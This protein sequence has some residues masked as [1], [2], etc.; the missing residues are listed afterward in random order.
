MTLGLKFAWGV[1][2]FT[3]AFLNLASGQVLYINEFMAS[4]TKTLTDEYAEYDDW[5]EIYNPGDTGVDLGGMYLTDDLTNLTKCRIPTTDPG[6]TTI[7]PH[8]FM[9]F[10]FDDKPAQGVRHINTKL[11]GSG[12]Q[13]GLVAA[14]G[15]TIIDSITFGQQTADVS[16][17]RKPD[18]TSNWFLF[19]QATPGAANTTGGVNPPT[20]PP[21]FSQAGGFYTAG[22]DLTLSAT[23]PTAHICYT[24]D[25]SEPT[26]NASL[27]PYPY[28]FQEIRNL[29]KVDGTGPT[30]TRYSQTYLYSG[31][32]T[33]NPTQVNNPARVVRARVFDSGHSPSPIITQTYIF[34]NTSTLPVLSL[35]TTPTFLWSNTNN[36]DTGGIFVMGPGPYGARE[37]WFDPSNVWKDWERP[38]HVE[39]F[40]PSGILAFSLDAGIKLT[41][42]TTRLT[43]Q[44]PVTIH[45]RGDYGPKTIPYQVFPD[46]P[47]QEFGAL[48]FRCSGDDW[49]YT[50]FQ[51][52]MIT[53]L[54]KDLDVDIQAYR[55]AKAYVNGEY[56]GIYEIRER[57]NEEYLAAHYG[58]DSEM[59]DILEN[60]Q[61]VAAGDATN[62]QALMTYVRSH[63]TSLATTYSD[64]KGLMEMDNYIDYMITEIYAANTDWPGGNTRYWR[65]KITNGR[66]R[67]MLH[68]LD[69]GFAAPFGNSVSALNPNH[70]TLAFA[71]SDEKTWWSNPTWSTELFRKLLQSSEF[72]KE[73][74]RRFADY[75]NITFAPA[76]VIQH[77]NAKKAGI[78]AEMGAQIARWKDD[79]TPWSDAEGIKMSPIADL[80]HWNIQVNRLISFANQRPNF[81]R[82]HLQ[83][84][85]GYD[86][87][88]VTFNITPAGAGKIRVNRMNLPIPSGESWTGIYF[89]DVQLQMLALPNK[90]F[91]FQNWVGLTGGAIASKTPTGNLNITANFTPDATN[92][93]AV[94]ITEINYNSAP[95]FTP[96]N[97][98]ELYN[99]HDFPVDLSGW[100]FKD[101]N[102]NHVFVFP[103]NTAIGPKW[104][105]VLCEDK[106]SFHNCF[107]QVD[108]YIGN[109]GFGLKDSGEQLRLYDPEGMLV[110]SLIYDDTAPWPTE[111][112]GTGPT[113]ELKQLSLDNSLPSSW[114]TSPGHGSP[115]K[116]NS[117]H[118]YLLTTS[119]VNEHGTLSPASKYCDKN[120]AETLTATPDP[121]YRVKRWTGTDNDTSTATTNTITM[122]TAKTVTVEFELITGTQYQLTTTV[123]GGH[124]TL[125]PATGAFYDAGTVVNLAA[126]PNSGYRVKKWT[127]TDN[128]SSTSGSNTVTM[129]SAKT[130]TVEFELI[131][132]VRY[133]LTGS[134]VS[135]HGTIYPLSAIY[136]PGKTV[137]LTAVPDPGYRVKKWTGT[138]NDASTENTNTVTMTSDKTVTVEF[139]LIPIIQYKLTATVSGGNGTLFPPDGVFDPGKTVTLTATANSGYR[140]KKWTGTNYDTSTAKTNTVTMNSD[141]TVTVEFEKIDGATILPSTSPTGTEDGTG[142]TE[143]TTKPALPCAGAGPLL[144]V[145]LCLA[146]L[147]LG[148]AKPD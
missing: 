147:L 57:Q 44:K 81:V 74:V 95:D 136:D 141:K 73:F 106:I 90:G 34:N 35:S 129:A 68:D 52:A 130:V 71:S 110:D 16:Q 122:N 6:G 72:E 10:W 92:D 128:D 2:F 142:T 100:Q 99:P 138:D 113:L 27:T 42:G 31:P 111:P 37:D 104:Y 80:S 93:N 4:N 78:E 103:P 32:I 101:S 45:A 56:Y 63:D 135:G 121:G 5:V 9:I 126:A 19:S 15:A 76:R 91:K 132:P 33:I 94:F 89:T 40:E 83:S 98:I 131:P 118:C 67:W 3:A 120:S 86:P 96:G 134:V 148:A 105:L 25:G 140:V 41:G 29:A 114:A 107:P 55:P 144:A 14:D 102:D 139:E 47:F 8:G 17:G 23:S 117:I 30:E 20:D 7:D 50:L 64:L 123:T 127:G 66:W 70:D 77:I 65:P 13:I 58:V 137:A 49:V 54:V 62:Y 28:M 43:P 115:G 36:A 84:K 53:G 24:L 39:F 46:L 22:F 87:V 79:A 26:E 38:V 112:D 12:E 133:K 21:T 11:S 82:G 51:D 18:G 108:N 124:G 97:W 85:F 59:V 116:E 125:Q 88:N 143:D 145:A 109:L 69:Y 1:L 48:I 75:L 146:G 119:V 61:E 60:N